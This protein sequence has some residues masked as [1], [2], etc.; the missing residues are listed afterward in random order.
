VALG[1]RPRVARV[2]LQLERARHKRESTL[3]GDDLFVGRQ[4]HRLAVG[5]HPRR[6]GLVALHLRVVDQE[7]GAA[8]VADLADALTAV[9][10]VGDVP[11]R[12]LAHAEDQQVGLGV[13]QHRASHGIAPVIV[14]GDPPERGLDAPEHDRHVGVGL[15]TALR[16]HDGGATH[17]R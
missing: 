2:G 16:V 7:R 4:H 12:P 8:H 13:E 14:V 10:P 3:V 9:Q 1:Q 5:D 17:H 11:H 15:A 6:I